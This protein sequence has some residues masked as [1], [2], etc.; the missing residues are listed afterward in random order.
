MHCSL[1]YIWVTSWLRWHMLKHITK[2]P[3]RWFV[4]GVHLHACTVINAVARP[5]TTACH[6]CCPPV[7]TT[8]S[9]PCSVLQLGGTAVISTKRELAMWLAQVLCAPLLHG[10]H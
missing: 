2:M 3:D 4:T 10:L 8:H 1:E 9:G 6:T 7:H 5:H